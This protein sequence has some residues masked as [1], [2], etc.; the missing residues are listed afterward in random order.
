MKGS[1]WSIKRLN[2]AD[3]QAGNDVLDFLIDNKE[4][5]F[6]GS[7]LLANIAFVRDPDGRATQSVTFAFSALDLDRCGTTITNFHPGHDRF[8]CE[9]PL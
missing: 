1:A 3:E 4:P 8:I 9:K 7:P 5:C 6:Q 2:K